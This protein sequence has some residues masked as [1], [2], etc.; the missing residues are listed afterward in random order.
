ME[1]HRVNP[2]CQPC[3]R[4]IDPIGLSLENFDPTGKWRIKDGE[5]S[6]DA[7]GVLYDGTIM[8][9]PAGLR[10][11]L[12]K[13]EDVFLRTFTESLLTYALGRRLEAEDMP[14][15]RAIIRTAEASDYRMSSFIQGVVAASAFRM[16]AAEPVQT[17]NDRSADKK[18]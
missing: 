3:H 15:V 7:R 1:E 5:S 11:A 13:H 10:A 16:S 4:V 6:V 8:D 14:A 9:G 12:L 2:A 18:R 17:T